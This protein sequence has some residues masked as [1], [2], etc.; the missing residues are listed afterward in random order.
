MRHT[1]LPHSRLWPAASLL[2]CV[3]LG[4]ML[5]G[6]GTAPVEPLVTGPTSAMPVP[7]PMQLERV[8]TGSLFQPNAPISSLFT[9][10]RLPR[11]VGDTLKVDISESVNGSSKLSA[12]L[13]RTN[14]IAS[15]GPGQG[16]NVPI[17]VLRTL[18][19]L[20]MKAAGSDT[21]KGQGNA[22]NDTHFTGKIAVTVINVLSNGNLVV[23]GE[24][25][26]T[27]NKG[28]TTMRFSGVVNPLDIKGGNVVASVD[29]V[30]A[31]IEAVGEGDAADS[32]H[33]SWLQRVM[34]KTFSVW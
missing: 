12:D 7:P 27:F 24:R 15:K 30:N 32:A 14:A 13:S 11:A 25:T 3:L 5:S 34:T 17:G 31:K 20:D 4:T 16:G 6:C 18:L 10:Q 29:V 26:F 21:F 33:R 1:L 22:S 19:D 28:A 9:G 8:A 23:A 2:L